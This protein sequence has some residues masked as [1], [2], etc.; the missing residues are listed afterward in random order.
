MTDEGKW[1]A[2]FA[3]ESMFKA[4]HISAKRGPQVTMIAGPADPLGMIAYFAKAYQGKF[5]GDLEDISD[6]DREYYI[7]DI[8]KNVL[9]SPLETV[10]FSFHISGVTRGFTHQLVRQRVGAAYQQESMRFAVKEDF[11]VA[12]PESI[13]NVKTID[14]RAEAFCKQM[15]WWKSDGDFGLMD[16]NLWATALE[17]VTKHKTPLEEQRDLW[18]NAVDAVGSAYRDLVAKGMPAEEA[19]GLAP[20]NILTQVNYTSSLR[21]LLDHAGMRLCTQSQYE[22]KQVWQAMIQAIS[23]FGITQHYRTKDVASIHP[24]AVY[25]ESGDSQGDLAYEVDSHWQYKAIA[26]MFR[27]ICFQ[28]GK[29]K[30]GSD[31]D[32]YCN[33]RDQVNA[34]AEINRPP[35]EWE[36]EYDNVTEG[37]MGVIS[38]YNFNDPPIV[39]TQLGM[40]VFIPAIRREQWMHP[41]AARQKSGDWRSDEAKKNIEGRR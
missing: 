13:R 4:E 35:S 34:N 5:P 24:G 38:G 15:G 41:D 39:R 7:Q 40:P 14:Q 22:W 23:D 20:T 3:D 19:R 12:L 1:L 33:I 18:D 8:L 25:G 2:N 36:T 10:Q 31:F 32:R 17:T 30:F 9:G 6:T 21:G 11:P 37:A 29:C 26:N 16:D 28:T 27:P